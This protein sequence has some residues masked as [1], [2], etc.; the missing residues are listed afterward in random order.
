MIFKNAKA[1]HSAITDQVSLAERSAFANEN[2]RSQ[3]D[4]FALSAFTK[5]TCFLPLMH[6]LLLIWFQNF[7]KQKPILI[8]TDFGK[9][10]VVVCL[11]LF[12]FQLLRNVCR[13][14]SNSLLFQFIIYSGIIYCPRIGDQS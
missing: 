1:F 3:K 5:D 11:V 14:K 2:E 7:I 6:E 10:L 9:L 12:I 4:I 13:Y 8:R